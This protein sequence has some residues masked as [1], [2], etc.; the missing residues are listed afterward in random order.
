MWCKRIAANGKIWA[1]YLSKFNEE[2]QVAS[3]EII[4]FSR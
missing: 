3:L 4:R 1:S 2:S